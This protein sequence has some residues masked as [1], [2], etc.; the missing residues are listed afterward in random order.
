MKTFVHGGWKFSYNHKA[1]KQK[2]LIN[3]LK[4]IKCLYKHSPIMSGRMIFDENMKLV[5]DWNWLL[6]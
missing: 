3:D 4:V 2:D 1:V 5:Y 6:T